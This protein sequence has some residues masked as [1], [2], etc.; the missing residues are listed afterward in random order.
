DLNKEEIRAK[1]R[2]LKEKYPDYDTEVLAR[3]LIKHASRG[4]AVSAAAWGVLGGP[5]ALMGMG[6]D[7]AYL[8]T[9]QVGLILAVA[10][11]YG[12]DI[13]SPDRIDEI[14]FC[15][16]GEKVRK[17]LSLK[18]SQWMLNERIRLK[19]MSFIKGKRIAYFVP[20]LI[21]LVS[22][23]LWSYVNYYSTGKVGMRAIMLYSDKQPGE[24]ISLRSESNTEKEVQ[25]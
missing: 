7:L 24:N 5:I 14:Y 23:G 16:G 6:A 13:E 12:R 2:E 10:H 17:K 19:A 3:K 8:F 11:L 21:P 20:R 15:L 1:A 18:C 9:K 22:A 25:A 4:S